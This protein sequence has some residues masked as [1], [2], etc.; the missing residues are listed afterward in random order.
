MTEIV[1]AC[2]PEGSG[3]TPCCGQSPFDLPHTD[4]IA[5]H[6]EQVTCGGHAH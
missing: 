5:E 6:P 2:P 1:H 4:R 3:V